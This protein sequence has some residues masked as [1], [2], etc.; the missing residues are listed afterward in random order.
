MIRNEVTENG[1]VIEYVEI[2]KVGDSYVTDDNGTERPSTEEEVNQYIAYEKLQQSQDISTL[3]QEAREAVSGYSPSNGLRRA[4]EALAD[5][6][7]A[8]E[9]S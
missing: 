6:L 4:V 1:V 9:N 5:A 7:E 8:R 3:T 2:K